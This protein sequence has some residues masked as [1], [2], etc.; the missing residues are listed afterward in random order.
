MLQDRKSTPMPISCVIKRRQK[1]T[2]ER[3]LR[4]LACCHANLASVLSHTKI[5]TL[6]Y[7]SLQTRIKLRIGYSMHVTEIMIYDWSLGLVIVYFFK[8]CARNFL[9]S[10]LCNENPAPEMAVIFLESIYGDGFWH[11]C[12]MVL[13]RTL[14]HAIILS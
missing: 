6:I 14:F 1:A 11:L 3:R 4:F 9:S 12:I 5:R 2:L 10:A 8:F 13:I 7:R